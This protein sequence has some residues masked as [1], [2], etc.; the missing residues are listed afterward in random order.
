MDTLNELDLSNL[1]DMFSSSGTF[2]DFDACRMPHLGSPMSASQDAP[3]NEERFSDST[4][5]AFCI[6]A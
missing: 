5:A 3:V 2:A 1:A 4:T 6:I